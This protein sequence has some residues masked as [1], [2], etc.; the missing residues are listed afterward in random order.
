MTALVLSLLMLG[1]CGPRGCPSPGGGLPSMP[2]F[3]PQVPYFVQPP[4]FVPAP[5]PVVQ[6]PPIQDGV[7]SGKLHRVEIEHADGSR[8]W[9]TFGTPRAAKLSLD[10]ANHNAVVNMEG[11]YFTASKSKC[12]N[13]Q[14][15]CADCKCEPCNC[16]KTVAVGQTLNFGIDERK[17]GERGKRNRYST[18]DG[19]EITKSETNQLLRGDGELP[20]DST[21][22]MLAVI[23]TPEQCDKVKKDI[24]SDPSFA[25]LR[26]KLLVQCYQ[27]EDEMVKRKGF[28]AGSP[29]IYLQDATGKTKWREVEYRG[30]KILAGEI[31]K[32]R[33][34]YDPNKDPGPSNPDKPGPLIPA[35]IDWRALTSHPLFLIGAVFAGLFMISK[36]PVKV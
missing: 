16:G 24:D 5:P 8:W 7:A 20:N 35:N 33:P 10:S 22:D 14:C 3:A 19:K 36:Q 31:D 26:D 15:T 34:D 29:S 9:Y 28:A 2:F 13:P 25:P 11:E 12:S 21:Y 32:R 6:Q 18:N 30:P 17:L 27:P 4:P 23:G 1:Q